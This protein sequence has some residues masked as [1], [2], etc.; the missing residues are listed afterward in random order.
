LGKAE[1]SLPR[2]AE[3]DGSGS[4]I[5]AKMTWFRAVTAVAMPLLLLSASACGSQST[6]NARAEP[7][8]PSTEIVARD[9][10]RRNF[11]RS[12]V[13]DNEWF[14]LRPGIQ[15]VTEGS[16]LEDGRRVPHRLVFTVTDLTKVI[17]G[18]RTLV[19]WDRDYSAGRL[20]ETELAFFAQDN[21][22]NVWELG[23]HPEAYEDGKLV[24]SPTWIHR[25]KGARAGL[26]MKAKPRPGA[27]S[28]SLGWGPAVGF[29]DRARVRRIGQ[30]TC[31]PLRC[32]EDVLVVAEFNP[33]EPGRY[34]L[35]YYASGVGN[36]RVGWEGAKDTSK[37]TL[38]LVKAVR[39]S[40]AALARA[41]EDAL[42]LEKSAYRISKD[43][44]G[45][46][47]PA[48]RR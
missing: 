29:N 34:Q 27:S 13:I 39:L 26:S 3:P 20:V 48:A 28:Y 14:P 5:G 18:V 44:Y 25:V 35:K 33:D 41:R 8:S 6:P 11:D 9:F 36:V 46:T 4:T 22:G 42:R 10:D 24:E 17:A 45:R 32:Y 2:G 15:L 7:E 12:T 37:E 16:T 38:A 47:P 30:R 40:P 43:V 23:E 21:D 31:V 19:I 1:V